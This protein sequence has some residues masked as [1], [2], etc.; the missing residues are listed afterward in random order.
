MSSG[1]DPV[2]F[3][4]LDH[5]DRL[6]ISDKATKTQPYYNCPVCGGGSLMVN[7]MGKFSCFSSGCSSKDIIEAIKPW[8][9][10]KAER[11]EQN[12]S[13]SARWVKPSR[14]KATFEYFYPDVNGESLVKVVISYPGD[15][16]K[17]DVRQRWWDGQIWQTHDMPDTVKKKVRL[18]QIDHPVNQDAIATGKPII[19]GESESKVELCLSMGIAAT[20]NINGSGSWESY[21]GVANLYV[22]SLKEANIVLSPDR[23]KSGLAHCLRIAQDFPNAQWLYADPLNS[24]WD[25]LNQS[26]YKAIGG[27]AP[28]V[29][30]LTPS[31]HESNLPS[32][33][34]GDELWNWLNGDEFDLKN[35]IE[36][37][38][39]PDIAR[40]LI[41][42]AIEPQRP[43]EIKKLSPDLL[44]FGSVTTSSVSSEN[45]SA[46]FFLLGYFFL[47]P[48]SIG[49][50]SQLVSAESFKELNSQIYSACL[51]LYE[52]GSHVDILSVHSVLLER[53]LGDR[54]SQQFLVDLKDRAKQFE[55][56][57]VMFHAKI[58]ADNYILRQGQKLGL[59]VSKLFVAGTKDVSTILAEAQTRFSDFT[60][61]KAK[62]DV[63][64]NIGSVLKKYAESIAK[65][66]EENNGELKTQY[67]TTGV[68]QFDDRVKFPLGSLIG[69]I[70]SSSHGK[71]TWAIQACRVFA[72]ETKLPTIF[73]SYEI[74]AVAA[75]LKH[76][77]METGLSINNLRSQTFCDGKDK[78][79]FEN[80]SDAYAESSMYVYESNDSAE[81]LCANLRAFAAQHGQIGCVCIDYIQ[82]IKLERSTGSTTSDLDTVAERLDSLRKELNC[83][84]IW[85]IQ[86]TKDVES[87]TNKRPQFSDARGT[88]IYRQKVDG[89]FYLF[90]EERYLPTPSNRGIIEIGC[91]KYRDGEATWHI[92]VPFD[93]RNSRVGTDFKPI[94]DMIEITQTE[95]TEQLTLSSQPL[96]PPRI[97][98]GGAIPE[99]EVNEVDWRNEDF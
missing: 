36:E 67:F 29:T 48:K 73:C 50:V 93:G 57:D 41:S 46:E 21:G 24:K 95:T 33:S 20:C 13:K 1:L 51:D 99:P 62:S 69:V 78:A 38:A 43:Y 17:K 76:V 71:T 52:K 86:P 83:V 56:S 88:A 96:L 18:Y 37:I 81:R 64:V 72:L 27:K 58:V 63:I 40:Q 70:A 26:F 44:D 59:E 7:K 49:A 34:N 23:G 80:V 65:E 61:S 77:V 31:W 91:E 45:L 82:L 79:L 14:P 16:G 98:L 30:D 42:D 39:N 84:M 60:R 2:R 8:E 90:R 85:L 87:R 92:K 5:L 54:I 28:K 19:V 15:G 3:N 11:A 22:P 47:E 68:S 53:G 75:G 66:K 74:S 97:D 9:E 12:A 89:G 55:D 4:I 32:L 25:D 10:V 94:L 35:W 6:T